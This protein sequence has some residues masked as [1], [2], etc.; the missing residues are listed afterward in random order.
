M[1]FGAFFVN[2]PSSQESTQF[3]PSSTEPGANSQ[4]RLQFDRTGRP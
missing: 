3:D 1:Y 2:F 4:V